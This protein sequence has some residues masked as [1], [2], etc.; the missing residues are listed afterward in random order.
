MNEVTGKTKKSFYA[1]LIALI[2][3]LLI[4][5]IIRSAYFHHLLIMIGLAALLG[6]SNRLIINSGAWFM[7]MASFYAIGA[8]GLVLLREHV[9]MGYWSA[10]PVI[11]LIAATI[12]LILGYATSR[13][14]GIPF[15]IISVAFAEV[16]R[17]TIIKTPFLGG[18]KAWVCP[19]PETI[20]GIT[21]TSKISIYYLILVLCVIVGFLFHR[22]EKTPIGNALMT[23]AENEELA[24]SIGINTTRY[25]VVVL[26]VGAFVAALTGTLFASYIGIIGPTSFSL[27]TSV[28]I[29]MTIVVGGMAT[30]WGPITGAAFLTLL[31]EILPGQAADQNIAYATIVLLTLFWLREGLIS[32]PKQLKTYLD[33]RAAHKPASI[34]GR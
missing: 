21:F 28:I 29:I 2:L 15:A 12:A 16:I 3:L 13:V 14:R 10:V 5:L 8:Y 26:M 20:F 4:P 18:H 11:G 6:M 1:Y 24:E 34:S 31:P 25:K 9:G 22:L 33:G 30:I 23:M 7:G 17:L 32:L 19:P 27:M